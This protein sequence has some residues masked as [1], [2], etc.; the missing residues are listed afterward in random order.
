[1]R[2]WSGSGACKALYNP[3]VGR[4]LILHAACRWKNSRVAHGTRVLEDPRSLEERQLEA[5]LSKQLRQ[6]YKN[7]RANARKEKRLAHEAMMQKAS[8]EMAR[9]DAALDTESAL[10]DTS[11]MMGD[12]PVVDEEEI[13][14]LDAFQA[15]TQAESG[16]ISFDGLRQALVQVLGRGVSR[17]E[18]RAAVV[19]S[20]AGMTDVAERQYDMEEFRRYQ[21]QTAAPYVPP[22]STLYFSHRTL[23]RQPVSTNFSALKGQTSRRPLLWAQMAAAAISAHRLLQPV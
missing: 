4:A 2:C 11:S 1:M 18:I 12:E 5:E 14:L 23:E 8:E 20:L 21:K 7:M 6:L 17:S 15:A 22:P 19:E 9:Q 13:E 3:R 10:S 16:H